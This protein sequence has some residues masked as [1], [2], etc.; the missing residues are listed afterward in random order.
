MNSSLNLTQL[1]TTAA[2]RASDYLR[3][4]E[5]PVDPAVWTPKGQHDFVTICDRE[6]ESIIAEVLLRGEPGSVVMGEELSPERQRGKLTWIVDPIDGTTNFIHGFPAYAVSIAAEVDGVLEAGVVL[7]VGP[8]RLYH[9]ARGHGAWCDDMRL[10]VSAI[11]SPGFALIGT[12]FP[13]KH[14]E[15]LAAYQPQFARIA[16]ATS[17]IRRAGSAALDLCWVAAGMFD[18]FWELMLAPWDMAAGVLLTREAG[19]RVTDLSGRDIGAA[20]AAVV[21]GNPSIHAWLLETLASAAG[22]TRPG[23]ESSARPQ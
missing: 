20:H 3:Q 17:G 7:H 6:A 8:N 16:M 2:A 22:P 10:G 12:G 13:F 21:A 5:R 1:A 19:G 9:A 23:S 15:H 4:V 18:G 14:P 11:D